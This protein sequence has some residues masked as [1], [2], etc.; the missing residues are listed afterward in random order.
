VN[1]VN[2]LHAHGIYAEVNIFWAA[3][4]TTKATG[5]PELLDADHGTAA[6]QTMANA[7]KNDPNTILGITEEP[8]NVS[9]ACWLNGGSSCSL[10]YTALGMQ[11]AVNAIRSTGAQNVIEVSG[12]DYA[13]DLSQWLT[14]KPSDPLGQLVAQGD[15]YGNN[16]CGTPT[17]FDST[18]APVAAKMPVIMGEIGETYDDSSSGTS[19]TQAIVGWDEGHGVSYA[20]WTWDTWGTPLSLISNYNGTPANAY[21]TWIRN[22]YLNLGATAP[23][24]VHRSAQPTDFNGDGKADATV[25]RPSTGWWYVHGVGSFLWG[26]GN[27]D[28]PMPADYDGD[29][30]ADQAVFRS[31]TGYWYIH[32]LGSFQWGQPGDI[33]VAADYNGDGKADAAV[34]RPSNGTW[35]IHGVATVVYGT[36]GDIPV[37]GDFN[38][39]G[40]ADVAV[41]RPSTGWWYVHGVGAFLWG[42]KGD[43]PVPADYNGDGKTDLAVFRPSTGY[44]Y[45]KGLG[46]SRWGQAG[47]IPLAADY[48]GDGKADAAVFR[49]SNSYW[50]IAGVSTF[51][52]GTPGDIPR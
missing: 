14:Y 42:T 28:I 51:L 9:W 47:D 1:Y 39:D 6:L 11:G 35:Y 29:G 52:Y 16:T 50:Y 22:H 8:H 43:I 13:N 44:W 20:A 3:S 45:I 33:P 48:N 12:R 46:S 37:A 36:N 19:N 26:G 41:F 25:F 15:F 17:C 49:P 18:I 30:K 32:G 40:K 23:P 24:P 4:G 27:G 7:F 21:G 34:F 10:G 38:G 5:Q 31:S 2:L